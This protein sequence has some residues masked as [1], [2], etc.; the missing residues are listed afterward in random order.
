IWSDG[1]DQDKVRPD[2]ITLALKKDGTL[3]EDSKQ[4]ITVDG[5]KNKDVAVWKK[6]PVYH[7][8]KTKIHYTVVEFNGDKEVTDSYDDEYTTVYSG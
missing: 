5:S 8:D 6:L 3:I 2:K 4:E 1:N 7:P